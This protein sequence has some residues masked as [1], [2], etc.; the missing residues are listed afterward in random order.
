MDMRE[1]SV[2][3]SQPKTAVLTR[4]QTI[5]RKRFHG[6]KQSFAND[7]TKKRRQQFSTRGF[8]YKRRKERKKCEKGIVRQILFLGDVKNIKERNV[9]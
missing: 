9:L 8:N 2:L 6:L 1:C 5:I 4:A 7:S 3:L